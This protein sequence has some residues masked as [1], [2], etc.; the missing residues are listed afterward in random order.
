MVAIPQALFDERGQ[1]GGKVGGEA[2]CV[3]NNEPIAANDYY[4]A[5]KY[6][7]TQALL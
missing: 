2:F 4:L 1:P 3:S 6:F 7:F 5:L